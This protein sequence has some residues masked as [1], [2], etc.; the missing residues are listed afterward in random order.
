MELEKILALNDLEI[1]DFEQMLDDAEAAASNDWAIN[2]ASDMNARYLKYKK[3][4]LVSP[5][6]LA[7]LKEISGWST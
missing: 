5:N 7:K 4:M 1:E 3:K 2:F 6:Q